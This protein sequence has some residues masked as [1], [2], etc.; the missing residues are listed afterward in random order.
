[1]QWH[2]T[3]QCTSPYDLNMEREYC[4]IRVPCAEW[5]PEKKWI[6]YV[7]DQAENNKN[8]P[9]RVVKG[10]GSWVYG[11]W[12]RLKGNEKIETESQAVMGNIMKWQFQ[13]CFQQQERSWVQHIN[14][15]R[16]YSEGVNT[17]LELNLSHYATA[18]N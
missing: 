9:C 6:F 2:G 4:K 13:T 16:D 17:Y 11:L 10:D 15:E 8:F 1:M 12:P 5:W 7:Q 14:Y 18:V 3:C